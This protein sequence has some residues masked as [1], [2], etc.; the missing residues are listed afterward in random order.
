MSDDHQLTIRKLLL[1]D[2]DNHNASEHSIVI[3]GFIDIFNLRVLAFLMCRGEYEYKAKA[4]YKLLFDRK[5]ALDT[6]P[7][8]SWSLPKLYPWVVKCFYYINMNPFIY[9][10]PY[11]AELEAK[12]YKRKTGVSSV[13]NDAASWDPKLPYNDAVKFSNAVD[14]IFEKEFLDRLFGDNNTIK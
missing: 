8:I 11:I 6:K 13:P 5:D 7:M 12:A 14:H 4:L 10:Q 3:N 1:L 9:Q 2:L